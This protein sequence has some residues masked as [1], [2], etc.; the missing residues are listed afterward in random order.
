LVSDSH[1]PVAE[2][3]TSLVPVSLEG[4]SQQATLQ[5]QV[6]GTPAY[7]APEQAEGRLDLLSPAT[8]VYGLGAVLYEI[9]TGQPPFIGP[10]DEV[11]RRVPREEPPRP[12][13]CVPVTPP[14]LEAVCLKALAKKPAERYSSATELAREVERWLA[15]EPVKAWREPWHLRARRWA[16]RNRSLV[17]AAAAALLVVLVLGGAGAVWLAREQERQQ[18]AAEKALDGAAALQEQARWAEARATLDQALTQLGQAGPADLRQRLK[19][20]RDHLDLLAE[21]DAIRLD[22]A[23]FREGWFDDAGTARR[24]AQALARAG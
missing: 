12:R 11:C 5:G 2:E 9:L 15:D 10:G 17:S 7:M 20:A 4:D 6:L 24:Y 23:T 3:A 18:A 14:G 19:E 8:D 1:A 13:Q 21:L 16:R 22:R